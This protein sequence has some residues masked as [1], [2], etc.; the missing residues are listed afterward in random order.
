M[1]LPLRSH[2]TGAVLALRLTPNASHNQIT[3]LSEDAAGNWRLNVRV[4][5]VPQKG[6]ANLALLKLL[7]KSLNIRRSDIQIVRGETE[8]NKSVLISGDP[9]QLMR[10]LAR[11]LKEL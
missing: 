3:G 6:K 4:T 1:S 5:A 11:Q 7:S 8:R 2:T 10:D 9:E